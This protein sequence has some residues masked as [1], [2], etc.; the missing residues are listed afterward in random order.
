MTPYQLKQQPP[1]YIVPEYASLMEVTP[2]PL[3]LLTDPLPTGKVLPANLII[4][5]CQQNNDPS[6]TV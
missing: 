6:P 4:L 2:Y 5:P 1:I 3:T